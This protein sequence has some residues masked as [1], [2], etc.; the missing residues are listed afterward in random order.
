M[1]G[2]CHEPSADALHTVLVRPAGP[3]A[4][5]EVTCGDEQVSR[6]VTARVAK[7]ATKPG[8]DPP[9]ADPKE[10]APMSPTASRPRIAVRVAAPAVA[11]LTAGDGLREPRVRKAPP[12]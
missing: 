5:R 2:T 6:I 12:S 4:A 9:L 7:G 11:A 3:A 8:P 1:P 10:Q